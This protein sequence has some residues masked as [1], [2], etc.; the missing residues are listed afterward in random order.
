MVGARIPRQ[1]PVPAD[2]AAFTA[3]TL[4]LGL[5]GETL[6]LT[7]SLLPLADRFS[8]AAACKALLACSQD[9]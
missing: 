3:S 5:P 6:A 1:R 8:L 2:A 7:A 4:L 9:W